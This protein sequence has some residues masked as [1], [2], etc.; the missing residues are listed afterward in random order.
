MAAFFKM[1]FTITLYLSVIIT[2]NH[3]SQVSAN[4]ILE[5]SETRTTVVEF[6]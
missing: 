1:F 5:K 2:Y 4:F 3:L 6:V